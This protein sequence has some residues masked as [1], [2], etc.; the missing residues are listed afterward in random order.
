MGLGRL[1]HRSDDDPGP[2]GGVPPDMVPGGVGR[3]DLIAFCLRPGGASGSL[4]A[5]QGH[6]VG[7]WRLPK[8][9]QEHIGTQLP[10]VCVRFASGSPHD[11]GH[12]TSRLLHPRTTRSSRRIKD[13]A[14]S[15]CFSIGSSISS[16]QGSQDRSCS[17]V[18]RC[19]EVS[20]TMSLRL[21]RTVFE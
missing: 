15:R 13:L 6:E 10:P 5:A 18:S 16:A 14:G 19:T 9:M 12:G 8:P 1:S 21:M 7:R 4:S 17:T 2:M 20:L 11:R 3:G